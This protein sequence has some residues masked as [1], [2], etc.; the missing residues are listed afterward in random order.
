MSL[1]KVGLESGRLEAML[2]DDVLAPAPILGQEQA[3][4][5]SARRILGDCR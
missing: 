3:E 5:V 4:A 2:F 1:S